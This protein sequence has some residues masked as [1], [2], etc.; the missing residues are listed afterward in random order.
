MLRLHYTSC[1]SIRNLKAYTFN[2]KRSQNIFLQQ[3]NRNILY[4]GTSF[5]RLHEY[6]ALRNLGVLSENPWILGMGHINNCMLESEFDF[7]RISKVTNKISR[8]HVVGSAARDLLFKE[9]LKNRNN[10]DTNIQKNKVL[11]N[12]PHWFE[13]KLIKK[14]EQIKFFYEIFKILKAF[15]LDI[16]VSLHPK[17]NILDYQWLINDDLINVDNT[18]IA[19]LI[20]KCDMY[21]G[22]FSSVNYWAHLCKKNVIL[23]N[24]AKQQYPEIINFYNEIYAN[25][26]DEFEAALEHFK[27]KKLDENKNL[28]HETHLQL[29][30]F[31][32]KSILRIEKI[33]A[34][35]KYMKSIFNALSLVGVGL[36]PYLLNFI[37]LPLFANFISPEGFGIIGIII[38]TATIALLG[39]V[40]N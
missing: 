19:E 7:H 10:Q 1:L 33:L 17:M 3:D 39:A 14:T 18:D 29:R 20:P 27:Y 8:Y 25:N 40:C 30:P 28:N 23:I 35:E 2:S 16:T 37:F 9:K 13:H 36:L 11:V 31:D 4:K 5:Y 24:F 15:Q 21:I 26:I 32:G 6:Y 38:A 34:K 12:L 22:S